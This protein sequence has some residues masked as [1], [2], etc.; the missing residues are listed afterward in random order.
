MDSRSVFLLVLLDL[1]GAFSTTG[2][3][4]LVIWLSRMGLGKY[5]ECSVRSSWREALKNNSSASSLWDPSEFCSVSH[6]IYHIY[7]I[8]RRSWA[9]STDDSQ[10]YF[11]SPYNSKEAGSDSV[12]DANN[13]PDEDQQTE[14]R[15]EC[16][17]SKAYKE[18]GT[19]PVLVGA[20]A[21][22]NLGPLP[23]CT[24]GLIP[25]LIC[26]QFSRGTECIC[27]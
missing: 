10:L 16:F 11:S 3:G 27:S 17:W 25:E 12:S 1:L 6:A 21:Y 14:T 2:C 4:I 8:I 7:E 23:G 19:Q 24:C 5:Q 18:I 13:R 9:E 20:T 15:Q 22:W 26:P